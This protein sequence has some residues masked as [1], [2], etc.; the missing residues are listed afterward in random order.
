ML[1]VQHFEGRT[2]MV[3]VFGEVAEIIGGIGRDHFAG[4]ALDVLRKAIGI[5]HI[6]M[7]RFG[8]NGAIDYHEATTLG[9]SYKDENAA[10]QY[11]RRFN[12]LDPVRSL[13]RRGLPRGTVLVV[14]NRAEDI[15]DPLYRREC[16]TEPEIGERLALYGRVGRRTLQVNV[17]RRASRECFDDH[18]ASTFARIATVLLP[19]AARHAEFATGGDEQDGLRLSL[20]ALKHRVERLQCGLSEREL[21]VCARA[22]YGQSIDGT[23]LELNIA[24]TSVVTYRRRAYAKLRISGYNELVAL[25]FRTA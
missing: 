22:L 1:W 9:G 18:A 16:Y 15:V 5:D 6:S 12:R 10:K 8:T 19:S 13:C 11:F 2:E 7:F 20:V 21:E 23:G 24:R 3:P 4:A 14:R 25:A 17:Y